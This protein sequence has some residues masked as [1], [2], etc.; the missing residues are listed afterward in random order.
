MIKACALIDILL[1]KKLAF[2][3]F[4]TTA[5]RKYKKNIEREGKKCSFI[6]VCLFL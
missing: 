4:L 3:R 2:I 1:E 6:K 5:G